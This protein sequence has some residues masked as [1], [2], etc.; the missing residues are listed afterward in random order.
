MLP[1]NIFSISDS[2]NPASSIAGNRFG[3]SA[4]LSSPFVQVRNSWF[5][6]RMYG[7]KVIERQDADWLSDA[8]LMLN[9][10]R[11]HMYLLRG[12]ATDAL[13]TKDEDVERLARSL[14]FGRGSR[15]SF[16]ERYRRITRRARQVCDRLF[17]G[18][19]EGS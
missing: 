7:A 17:Y 3:I 12:L 9:R 6:L 16:F 15:S 19:T 2:L 5:V 14:G 10:V 18:E 1:P 4:L 11:N 8:Y 13:P